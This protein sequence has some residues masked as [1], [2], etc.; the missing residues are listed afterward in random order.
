MPAINLSNLYSQTF[1]SLLSSGTSNPWTNDGTI[2][3]W[4]SNRT[5]YRASTG[6]DNTGALYSFGNASDRALGAIASGGTGTNLWGVRLVND[7]SNTISSLNISFVGEQWR[8]AGSSSTTPGVAQT[9][10][11]QYQIGATSLTSG[12]WTDFNSLDFTSPVFGTISPTALDGNSAANRTTLSSTLS[13]LNIAPGQEIWLR[14]SDLNDAN[15]DH[16]L[17]ID[18][19][20]V[21]AGDGTLPP[22]VPT[23][24]INAIAEANEVGTIP[25]VFRITRTGDPTAALTVNYTIAGQA[26]N[27][28]DYT[29]NLTGT[30][31]IAANQS[32]VDIT[33]TPVDDG[34]V[35][36]NE[37]VALTLVDTANYDLGSSSNATVTIRDR[38]PTTRIR[39]IQGTTHISPLNGQN[40]TAVPGI[41]TVVR[42]NGFYLQD[43]TDDGNAATSEAIFVFRGS[44]S[45]PNVGDSVLVNGTVS[46][47]RPG[48][49]ANNLT[50]TQ[51]SS[52]T[53]T[54][55]STGNSLP[56]ATIIGNGGRILPTQIISSV[57][58]NVETSGATLNPTNSG[59]DFFESLEGMRVQVNNGAVVGPTN[60]FG[61][62]WVLADGGANATGVNSRGGITISAGDFNPERIQIDDTLLPSPSPATNVGDRINTITG[63]ID[64]NFNNYELLAT[65]PLAV[66]PGNL[67]KETTNLTKGDDQL[68][69]A[70]FNVEN[71]DPNP[72]DGDDDTTRFQQI[73]N[74][75][76]NNLQAPDII[77]LQEIQDNNGAIN[78]SVVDASLTYQTLID[79]IATAGGPR[80]EFRDIPPVDDQDGGQPG[81]NI[82]VGFLF[83]PNRVSFVSAERIDPTNPAFN[84]SRKPLAGVFRFNEAPGFLL[85]G[86]SINPGNT[87]TVIVNHFNSKGGDQP[88]YGP[89][90]PPNL[91]SEPQRIQQ[92]QIVNNYV[93]NLLTADPNANVIVLGDL[94]DFQFSEPLNV[95]RGVPGG[96]GTP[97][98]TD[99]ADALL[100]ENE[101]Y[102]YI[103]QGNSQAL[104]H[105]LATDNLRNSNAEVDIVHLNSEFADQ[106]SDHDPIVSR[107]NLPTVVNGTPN[108]DNLT[109]TNRN[110]TINGLAGNDFIL[111]NGGNDKI[112]GGAGN[113]D[114]MFGGAGSD[115]ITDPDGVNGAHGGTGN[116]TITVT[117]AP[118]WDNNTNPN[119]A[120]R[121][122]GKITGGYG[123]D[124]IT[125]TMNN[126]RFFLN[127][128]GDEP[129]NPI[130]NDPL[131]GNDAITLLGSYANSVVD[132][133]GGN[134][135]FNGGIGADNVSGSGGNDTL[136][137]GDGNDRLAGDAGDDFLNGGAGKNTVIGGAG[138]DRFVLSPL[139]VTDT[140]VDFT[141]GQDLIG[142][143]GLTFGQLTVA[144]GTGTNL[145]HTL[146]SVNDGSSTRLLAILQGVQSGNITAADFVAV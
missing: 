27:G 84:S 124:A 118:N 18:D 104:D 64:Y 20:A 70:T 114:R 95:L 87:V 125:V 1:D 72:N 106:V 63:I 115:I 12:T 47:F 3:G 98:L 83:N 129:V 86:T 6:S 79:A 75:I 69:V 73:A 137:G 36:G 128:K 132:L 55:V 126:S 28:V 130:S 45:K 22:A 77:G 14:W 53:F 76:A 19:L 112:N 80:Y 71:L 24:T 131:D 54:V 117:F 103:F 141:D 82:R 108:D 102:T 25:G 111:G 145:N 34:I 46:E 88:L 11:F 29:P 50:T 113:L 127:L 90:Q 60:E 49:N 91:T 10:D 26:T 135:T 38:I 52:A 136:L 40:V 121:S 43:P 138:N 37:T 30:A 109:G 89:N 48:N 13:G 65:S 100:P 9:L 146:I 81:A 85:N 97:V 101:Q 16:G 61:E 33:I 99:L 133:G 8:N 2:L 62:L 51:I 142:L 7:T 4:Y 93:D 23:V 39:E 139:T 56:N 119:D 144:Q 35:E 123:D 116:D 78:D 94:N 74:I 17:A 15:N 57:V 59:M 68:T 110:E 67:A 31:I 41:V 140:I 92:A 105:I 58:G 5:L 32:F 96:V 107:F 120:P 44:A 134:D 66:T 42:S 143:S 21:S 122:D